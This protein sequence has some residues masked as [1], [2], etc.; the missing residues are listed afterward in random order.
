MRYLV[1]GLV[2]SRV[3][4]LQNDYAAGIPSPL[5]FL[6]LS[7][8]ISYGLGFGFHNAKILPILYAVSP[9]VGRT[10]PEFTFKSS[11]QK[12][13]FAPVEIQEDMHGH[14]EFGFAIELPGIVNPEQIAK[15]LVGR[16]LAG[17]LIFNRQHGKQIRVQQISGDGSGLRDSP[18]GRVLIPGLR[19]DTRGQICFGGEGQIANIRDILAVRA[20]ENN[21]TPGLRVPVAIGFRLLTL[22]GQNPI[23]KFARDNHTPHV[24]GEPGLGVAELVSV[25]NRTLT[26]L[27]EEDFGELFWSWSVAGPHIV[28]HPSYNPSLSAH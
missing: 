4:L 25:R 12:R 26:E 18:R 23:P 15:Q 7:S 14:V 22:P 28:A 20:S 9:S 11:E 27:D 10:R 2:A 1:S 6:G 17:G 5:A 21:P 16:R 19:D 13:G 8:V 24:F 3:N